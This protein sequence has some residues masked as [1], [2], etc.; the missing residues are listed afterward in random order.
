M[1]Y[2]ETEG[3][4]CGKDK[5]CVQNSG[6]TPRRKEVSPR[7]VPGDEKYML[8]LANARNQRFNV[9]KHQS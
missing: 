7:T 1:G 4:K 5:I 3:E 6:F 9:D 8:P 2:I